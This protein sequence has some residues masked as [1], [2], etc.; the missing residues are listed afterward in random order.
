M[1]RIID[2]I[3]GIIRPSEPE[4]EYRPY[5]ASSKRLQVDELAQV[6][7]GKG[8][9][10][11]Q[12]LKFV[13]GVRPRIIQAFRDVELEDLFSQS[14]AVGRVGRFSDIAVQG[15]RHISSPRASVEL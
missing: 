7:L 1:G 4:P 11:R 8:A 15:K 9:L 3:R 14:F 5:I 2:L 13:D 6:Q 12:G 10:I